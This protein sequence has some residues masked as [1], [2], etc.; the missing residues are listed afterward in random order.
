[1][2][3]VPR[4]IVSWLLVIAYVVV[5]VAGEAVHSLDCCDAGGVVEVAAVSSGTSR[6]T[7]V[8]ASSA[9][10]LPLPRKLQLSPSFRWRLWSLRM[11]RLFLHPSI[12]CSHAAR[13]GLERLPP[14]LN[15]VC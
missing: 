12:C 14:D 2:S 9:R 4:I 1:M 15:A 13:A 6:T 11:H 7:A 10:C 3:S 8:T 5:T